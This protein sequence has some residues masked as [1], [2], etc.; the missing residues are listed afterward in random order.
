MRPVLG[1][2]TSCDETA[3]AVLDEDGRVLAEAVAAGSLQLDPGA[4]RAETEAALQTIPGIGPWTAQ[5]VS[6]RALGDPDIML[7]SD[8]GAFIL[9]QTIVAD[10]GCLAAGGWYKTPNRWVN[11]PLLV[12]YFEDDPEGKTATRPATLR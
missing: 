3:T 4:D 9:G 8:L 10:G 6:M 1:I 7:A 11:S 5:Y 2:E 12:Q